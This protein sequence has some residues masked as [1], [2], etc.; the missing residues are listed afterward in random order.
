MTH[1]G[2]VGVADL[3]R[4]TR[5]RLLAGLLLAELATA[6]DGLAYAAVLPLASRDLDGGAWYAAVLAADGLA[7]LL[8]L[9]VAGPHVRRVPAPRLLAAGTLTYVAGSFTCALAG[10]MPV[11]LLGT[12]LRG[13]AGGLIAGLG[14]A[15]VGA[16]FPDDDRPRVMGLFAVVW[17]L[18]SVVG[19]VL[20][21]LI[22]GVAGWRPT[23]AW[24][25]LLL[26]AARLIVGRHLGM[27]PWQRTESRSRTGAALVVVAG[28]AVCAAAVPVLGAARAGAALGV[29]TAAVVAC[30]LAGRALLAG[31]TPERRR[32]SR[33][34]VVTGLTAACLAWYTASAVLPWAL[35]SGAGH[36]PL[37]TN[38][39]FCL[40]AAA[41]AL[42]GL[43]PP[44]REV[45]RGWWDLPARPRA[46]AVLLPAGLSGLGIALV[47]DVRAGHGPG[48]LVGASTAWFAAGIG[49]GL[50]YSRLSAA[51]FD[52]AEPEDVAAL[53]QAVAFA[54]L[55][56]LS[57][58]GVIGG[59][60]YAVRPA[61]GAP[62]AVGAAAG[63]AVAVL[64][65][66]LA[67]ALSPRSAGPEE[68]AAASPPGRSELPGDAAG[69]RPA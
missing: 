20:N 38:V 54:D 47:G 8:V 69:A 51:T 68:S 23:M 46:A 5:G 42:T 30:V 7:T 61:E 13:A 24:P 35:V 14:L 63:M 28:L 27:V 59:A 44:H 41:W 52:D 43:R 26:A 12:L 67:P 1:G 66:V 40:G 58:G 65:G 37:V 33:M 45:P 39:V 10:T 17:L 56:S 50:T 31:F 16:L 60:G 6:V 34:R 64:A 36:G 9:G 3:F 62:L 25:C 57:L 2:A 15:A 53:G 29:L 49:M 4:G 22:T 32:P 48:W 55:L 19:P 21:S 11:V 18:P